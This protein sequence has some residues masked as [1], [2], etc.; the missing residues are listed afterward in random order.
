[1]KKVFKMLFTVVLVLGLGIGGV[2]NVSAQEEFT[3]EEITVTAEKR[4]VNVQDTAIAITAMTGSAIRDKAYVTLDNV[5]QNIPTIQVQETQAGS[6]VFIRGIGSNIAGADPS[7]AVI[8]DGVFSSKRENMTGALYDIARIEVLKGPQGTLYGRNALGGTVNIVSNLPS[9]DRFETTVNFVMGDYNLKHVDG[10]L[11]FPLSEKWAGRIAA[12]R[13][14]RDGYLTNDGIN[15]DKTS[16]RVKILFKPNEDISFLGIV[17]RS[18]DRW[19]GPQ[20][21]PIPGSGGGNLAG[22]PMVPDY[23]EDLLTNGWTMPDGS[24]DNPWASDIYHPANTQNNRNL[25][26]SIQMDWNLEWGKLTMLPSVVDFRTYMQGET[27]F[28][29][30]AGFALMDRFGH[31]KQYT[32]EARLASPSESPFQWLIGYYG[33]K[34]PLVD[35]QTIQN[36]STYDD[37]RWHYVTYPKP[38]VT[39][40]FFGQATYP[41][42][43]RFRLTGGLRYFMD[44]RSR[45][46]AFGNSQV[47]PSDPL[48]PDAVDGVYY[49]GILHFKNKV[50]STTGL[51]S[52]EYDIKDDSMLY[53]KVS[54]G[55]KAGGLNGTTPPTEY[56]PEKLTSYEIGSKNRFLND[57]MQI[58]LAAYYYLYN[59]MQVM[60]QGMVLISDAT[61]EMG[62]APTTHNAK[63]GKKW[64]G[65]LEGDWLLTSKDRLTF[66]LT[67]MGGE[68]GEFVIPQNPMFGP[69]DGD[70]KLTGTEMAN[71]P[72]W[73]GTLGYQHS[74]DL[75]NEAK[76]SASFNTRL[77]TGYYVTIEKYVTG[78][79]QDGFTRSDAYV[80]YTS[81]DS[82]WVLSVWCKNLENQAQTTYVFPYYRR[83]ITNPRTTGVNISYNY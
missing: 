68:Y 75:D 50:T 6:E 13:E 65:E 83:M 2:F 35:Q 10:S 23:A 18:E 32:A 16:F 31:N 57:R 66:T 62:F 29:K 73:V 46:Y 55:F 82:R 25:T 24:G 74:W 56:E 76:I 64:G 81:A 22:M 15:S 39:H 48:Y 63:E 26:Y 12:L 47:D 49:S 9:T 69:F 43:D 77:S 20:T 4:E 7:T 42:T 71:S 72:E 78:S 5:L 38:T 37:N 36:P 51:A 79:Y 30:S 70:Y 21:L 3:L 27:L 33:Y 53:G 19:H 11:N 17:D 41:V 44:D 45:D 59:K 8:V 67:Y 58:N 14:T 80:K 52:I 61:G 60:L 54:T 1:M 40:A 28:G 34:T